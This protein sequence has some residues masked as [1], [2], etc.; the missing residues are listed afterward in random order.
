MAAFDKT[1]IA[2]LDSD[3]VSG[4]AP[5]VEYDGNTRVFTVTGR[6]N[7]NMADAKQQVI[8]L[9]DAATNAP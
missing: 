5:R 2:R 8:D 3:P 4:T 6:S 1:F 9:L 7:I